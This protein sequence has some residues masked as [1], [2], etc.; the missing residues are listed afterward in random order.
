L[1]SFKPNPHSIGAGWLYFAIALSFIFSIGIVEPL[2]LDR[3]L[4]ACQ[5]SIVFIVPIFATQPSHPAFA[6]A[7]FPLCGFF[8]CEA[9]LI[10]IFLRPEGYC[11]D[12]SMFISFL[13]TSYLDWDTS[14]EE[15]P[16]HCIAG[17]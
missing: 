9:Y 14:A 11:S 8:R 4:D 13:A 17:F 7:S 15:F 1:M 10:S 6:I 2:P 5:S 12:G 16:S 3:G